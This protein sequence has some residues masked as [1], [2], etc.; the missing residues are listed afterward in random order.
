MEG[1]IKTNLKEIFCEVA[2]WIHLTQARIS[3][4]LLW[5]RK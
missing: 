3:S 1:N 4:G 2:D 5:T